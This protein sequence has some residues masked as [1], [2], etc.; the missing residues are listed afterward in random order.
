MSR[1]GYDDYD[2][3]ETYPFELYR[4]AVD[5]ALFGKRGQAFLREMRDAFDALPRKELIA[6]MMEVEGAVCAIGAV[7][8]AR[9]VDM[10]ELNGMAEYDD[11]MELGPAV[12]KQ[13]GIAKSMAREIMYENDE[14]GPWRVKETPEDRY[15]RMRAWV[16]L[17]IIKD[18]E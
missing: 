15:V 8:K 13:F 12:A 3:D 17:N 2:G 1:S 18:D 6:S 14:N 7:G 11:S 10:T 5:N 9:G 4:Q 16:E